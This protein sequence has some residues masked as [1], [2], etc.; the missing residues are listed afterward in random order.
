MI[1]V[2]K[3]TRSYATGS[4]TI[5]ALGG[6]DLTIAAGEYVAIMGASGS[7]KSTLMNILGLLDRPTSG[8]Y[9]LDGLEVEKAEDATLS[10]LRNQKIGFVFQSF[11]LLA[12]T[13][14]LENV[15]LPL[16][17]AGVP[18][19]QRNLR[20]RE[21]LVRM[22]LE[23][24]LD[25]QPHQLSGG[26]QQRVAIARAIVNNPRLLLADEP[27]GALDSRTSDEIMGLFDTLHAQGMTLVLVTHEADVAAHAHRVVRFRDGHILSD[28]RQTP[29]RPGV[30]A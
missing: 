8:T 17:Y 6:V 1:E 29:R 12:R 23:E 16:V 30:P 2:S 15:G 9:R 18:A 4:Q 3:L 20:A 27:T 24:R 10:R 19:P 5:P 25:H 21:A 7:G 28:E 22:G 26:Q 14:A 13:P 11:H